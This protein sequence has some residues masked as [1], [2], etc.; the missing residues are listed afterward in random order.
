[1]SGAERIILYVPG[2]KPKPPVDI[3]RANL[4]RDLSAGLQR[5]NPQVAEELASQPDCLRIVP[6]P[7][8]FYPQPSDP[9]PDE[10][11]LQRLH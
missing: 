6:W 5:T 11:G 4:L 2:L 10:P 8:L 3:H 1:M 7:N 9:V